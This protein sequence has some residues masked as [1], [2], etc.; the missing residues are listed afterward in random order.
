[1]P[2]ETREKQYNVCLDA[3]SEF[4]REQ[5]GLMSSFTWLSDPKRLTFVLARYKFVAKMF[6]GYGRVLEVGCADAFASR[7]VKQEVDELTVS[8]FDPVFIADVEA[9]KHPRHPMGAQ[10]H[11]ILKGPVGKAFDGVFALD[12]LEHIEP[13]DEERFMRNVCGSLDPNGAVIIGMPSIESQ[14]YASEASKAGHVNCK[15]Q[16]DLKSLMSHHFHNV[17]MFSMND[18]IIHTGYARMAHYIIALGCGVRT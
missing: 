12:V 13:A 3:D 18:E 1:M 9:R 5:F 8:D 15:R 7:L 6:S 2:D 14:V 11:D 16:E 10:V 17:F 4:G